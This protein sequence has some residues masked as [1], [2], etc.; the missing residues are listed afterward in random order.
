LAF[1]QLTITRDDIDA[2]E[3]LTFSGVDITAPGSQV[4]L[5]ESDGL[6]VDKAIK[7][8]KTDILEELRSYIND[9]TY[10]TEEDL[11]D[12]IYAVDSEDLLK[13]VLVYKFFEIWFSQDA[14]HTD[15]YSYVK[16]GKYHR[17]YV[18]YLRANLRRL[19]GLLQK[20]KTVQRVRWISAY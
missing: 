13:D 8:L 19:S 11:L 18:Q 5:S 10:A 7:M 6:M 4:N 3:S 12:A 2:F 16:A 15:S 1:S 14:T 9:E 20:P 17:M